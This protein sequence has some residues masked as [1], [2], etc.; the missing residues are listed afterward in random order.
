[1]KHHGDLGKVLRSEKSKNH[2]N[3]QGQEGRCSKLSA[4]QFHSHAWEGGRAEL[5][6]GSRVLPAGDIH[7]RSSLRSPGTKLQALAES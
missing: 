4:G 2:S 5:Q 6:M 3:L 1:M 7:S